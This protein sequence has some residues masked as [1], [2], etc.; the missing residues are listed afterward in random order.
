MIVSR[1]RKYVRSS[2]SSGSPCSRACSSAAGTSGSSM[3]PYCTRTLNR[4]CPSGSI[5]HAIVGRHMRLLR[6]GHGEHD[7]VVV[8][9]LVVAKVVRERRRRAGR[10]RGHEDSGPGHAD[11]LYRLDRGHELVERDRARRQPLGDEAAP[12]LP[13]RHQREEQQRDRQR[14]P[15]ALQDLQRVGAEEREVDRSGT[16]PSRRTAAG[17]G[18]CQRSVMTTYSSSTVMTIVSVTA[19]P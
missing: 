3:N 11:R 18:H 2:G 5:G 13:G 16:A 4:S 1:P 8:E 14:D 7:D 19:M 10:L 6:R 12:G 15:A 9:H 17:F